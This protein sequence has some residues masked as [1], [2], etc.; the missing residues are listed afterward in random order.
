MIERIHVY[1]L[2][3]V[4][5]DTSHRY[6]NLSNGLIDLDYWITNRTFS[7]MQRDKILPHAK[8]YREN[9]I[10]KSVYTVLCTARVY[11]TL[12]IAWITNNIGMP[13]RLMM[14]PKNNYDMDAELKL[15]QLRPFFALKQFSNLPRTLW[16]DNPINID[17]L[18]C[19]FTHTIFVSSFIT[20]QVSK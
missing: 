6:R 16:E 19:L 5:V 7:N 3:G 18:G 8:Q 9:C 13:N 10:S 2:D 14:R 11:H 12:D 17:R 1:D 20:S 15:K 4:L